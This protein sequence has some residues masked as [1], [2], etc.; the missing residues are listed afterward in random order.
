FLYGPPGNGKTVISQAIR[1]VLI[2]DIAIPHAISVDNHIIRLFDPV[3]HEI[4]APEAEA[5]GLE[6]QPDIDLRWIR[7]R[8]PA[9]TVGGELTL[10]ALELGF[11]RAGFYRAPLQALAN[12]GV[13]VIDDFGRQHI[14][15]RDLL[16]RWV[17]PL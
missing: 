12:G 15:P 13:L 16:N 3:N 1:N 9:V 14:S 17:V 11:N 5:D 8:R 6:R 2:G 4:V 7:C 10:D